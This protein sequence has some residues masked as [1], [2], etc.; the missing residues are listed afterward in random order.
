M[1][2]QENW[3]LKGHL[4]LPF[5]TERSATDTTLPN[6][7]K[8]FVLFGWKSPSVIFHKN[9]SYPFRS[10]VDFQVERFKLL[11]IRSVRKDKHKVEGVF[12]C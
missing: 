12:D 7:R 2:R 10:K 1:K 6:E 9:C 3:A 11:A 8:I 4:Y 5:P